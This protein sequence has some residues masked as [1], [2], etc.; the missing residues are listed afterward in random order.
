MLVRDLFRGDF[1]RTAARRAPLAATLAILAGL[2]CHDDPAGP[3]I[4]PTAG[5]SFVPQFSSSAAMVVDFVRVRIVFLR[6]GTNQVALDTVV[7]FPSDADSI[8]LNL[9]VPTQGVGQSENLSFSLAMI[10]AAGDTV[11]RGGPNFVT[12]T[13]GGTTAPVLVP[14]HYTGVG[15]NAASVRI[16][17]RDTSVFFNDSVVLTAVAFDSANQ[18]ISGTPIEWTSL[19]TTRALVPHPNSGKVFGRTQRGPARIRARLVTGQADTGLVRVQPVPSALALLAGNGQSG[20]VGAAL[21]QPLAVRVTAVDGLGVVGVKV[22]FTVVSGGGTVDTLVVTDTAGSA[23]AQLRLGTLAGPDTVRAAVTGLT[24]SPVTFVATALPGAAKTLVI[25]VQPG[26]TAAGSP[27]APAVQVAARD[28]FGNAAT[29][30]TGTVTLA[31]GTNPASGT[32]S[33]TTAVAAVAGVATF[34]AVSINRPG[35]GYTLTAT[36]AGLAAAT[37]GAFSVVPG[38]PTRLGFGVQPD[39]TVAG[40]L[41]APAARVLILDA[42]GNTVTSATD[43]VTIAFGVNPAGGVLAGTLRVAAVA[44]VADFPSL[45]IAKA[46]TGYTLSATSGTLT[47]ATSSPFTISV[48]AAARLAFTVQPGATIAGVAIAPAPLVTVQDSVGNT[49][50]ASTASITV[51]IGTNPSSGTLSGTTIV[52]AVGGTASFSTL[53]IDKAGAGY[54][55]TAAASGLTGAT[56]SALTVSVGAAAKLAFTVQPS[57]VVL[58]AVITPAVQVTIQDAQGNSVTSATTSVTLAITSGTGTSGAV[59]GG[60]LTQAAIAGVATFSTLTVNKVGIGYTLTAT[61]TS[62]TGVTSSAF[63]ASVGAAAKLAF[64]VQPS[65]V[66]AGAAITPAVQV[67]VQDAQ[68]NTVTSATTSVTLAITSGTGTGGAVLGGTL[69]QSA[70]NG[71]ATFSGLTLDRVGTG[72]TLTAT[73]TGLTS[74]TSSAIAVTP[75]AAAALALVSGNSQIGTVSSGV[76]DSLV[77]KATDAFGNAVSGVT[78]N[79]STATGSLTAASTPTGAT[80][81]A[82]VRWT[83]GAPYGRQTAT[84][85]A[86]G[87]GTAATFQA[88][89][90]PAGTTHRWLGISGDWNTPANWSAGTEPVAASNVFIPASAFAPTAPTVSAPGAANDVVAET[91]TT[92]GLGANVLTVSGNLDVHT[93]TATTGGK[94]SLTGIG[95]TA[96]GALPA[97]DVAGRYALSGA[98]TVGGVLTLSGGANTGLKVNGFSLVADSLALPNSAVLVMQNAA[99]SAVINH[100]AWFNG[101]AAND[102]AMTAG[103]LRVRGDLNI[104]SGPNFAAAG[105]HRTVLDGSSPQTVTMAGAGVSPTAAHFRH[106]EIANTWSDTGVTFASTTTQVNGDLTL[107]AA[108]T[109]VRGPSS[110]LTVQGSVNGGLTTKLSL[111][112]LRIGGA[113]NQTGTYVAGLTEFFGTAQTIPVRPYQNVL[114]SGRASFTGATSIGGEL[115]INGTSAAATVNG[116]KVTIADSL[117][118]GDVGGYLVMRNPADQVVVNGHAYFNGTNPIQDTILTAGVLRLRR[119]LTV[120]YAPSFAASTTGAHRTVFDGPSG[121]GVQIIQFPAGSGSA[122][123]AAKFRD[124]V[125]SRPAAA[126]VVQIA[127]DVF[128]SDT[129][130][131]TDTAGTGRLESATNGALLMPATGVLRQ[132]RATGGVFVRRAEVG[133]IFLDSLGSATGIFSPDTVVF[134]A[135]GT[136][137]SGLGIAYKSVRIAAD[138]LTAP[139]A[140]TIPN[141]LVIGGASGQT[142]TLALDLTAVVSVGGNLRTE[143]QGSLNMRFST[144]SLS[145]AGNATFAGGSTSGRLTAG[146][147]QLS[148][149]FTQAGPT[150]TAFAPSGSHRVEF[151]SSALQTVSFANPGTGLSRFQKL[152]VVG[153]ASY[154]DTVQLLSDVFV[155]DSL[156]VR[157]KST[158]RGASPYRLVVGGNLVM[159]AVDTPSVRPF[160]LEVAG[161]LGDTT[162]LIAP[163]TLVLNRSDSYSIVQQPYK[164]LRVNNGTA[165]LPIVT[166]PGD[167]EVSGTGAV[168]IPTGTHTVTGNFRT[169]GSGTLQMQSADGLFV[170]QGNVTFAG[171]STST[172]LTAGTL[173]LKGNFAQSGSTTTA[174]APSGNHIVQFNGSG[175][176]TVTFASPGVDSSRFQVWQLLRPSNAVDSVQLA[177][178]VYVVDSI[179]VRYASVVGGKSPRRLVVGGNVR[180]GSLNSPALR[181]FVLEV[182]GTLG[183]TGVAAI[184]PDTLVYN[185]GGS[186]SIVQQPFKHLRVNSGTADLQVVMVAG[187]LEVSGTG[188]VSIPTSAHTVTGNF[189]TT[190]SGT[191]QMQTPTGS[192]VVQG[193]ATFAGGS[194]AG[195]LTAGLLLVGGNFTQLGTTSFQASGGPTGHTTIFTNPTVPQTVSF[196]APDTLSEGSGTHSGSHFGNMEMGVS[197]DTVKLLTDAAVQGTFLSGDISGPT[198]TGTHTLFTRGLSQSGLTIDGTLLVLLRGEPGQNPNFGSMTFRNQPKTATQFWIRRSETCLNFYGLTFETVPE[199]DG[200]YVGVENLSGSS[201]SIYFGSGSPASLEPFVERIGSPSI[202]WTGSWCGVY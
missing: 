176:Q 45:R 196:A 69:T 126:D 119:N 198:L 199:N 93:V 99:D 101:G 181:P 154:R 161:T 56:S 26:T 153:Q 117:V 189:S 63:A 4:S 36:A 74:A 114:V 118:V 167:L 191:L 168:S 14:I 51:A 62:L 78:V 129:A 201:Q 107:V 84:A 19:D 86:A 57:A 54:T 47:G 35:T 103:V 132:R 25:A 157:Y 43:S 17:V 111:S 147:L 200:H 67:T 100:G 131:V 15:S 179:A 202:N 148:G 178:N 97:V 158:I 83:L 194:T 40:A 171:G 104:A 50:T 59:L 64:T 9:A 143:G 41:L 134:L 145:V 37:T 24:G 22:R 89:A 49:V 120:P 18:P 82:Y 109:G 29:A 52:S 112:A 90:Q 34:S 184:Q 102:T 91:G 122:T 6:A 123:G 85:S 79:W 95:K 80:G 73:A 163:D 105:T 165:D 188:N 170:V 133:T 2:S 98:T 70:V 81:V 5:F 68:G 13:A 159:G 27:I 42:I 7:S 44:G 33:G 55:L 12:V 96:V 66:V 136:L 21:A 146:T 92:I 61:A 110:T 65:A 164:H 48:G 23:A 185:T 139:S 60:T 180:V 20:T 3:R 197:G 137:P 150:T 156:A 72:Y 1:A 28:T 138:T 58:G 30:F 71:V 8:T 175:L 16:A 39:T 193:K 38:A 53:S 140:L 160:V 128:V 187:D 177:S 77:V 162:N 195:L 94:L 121:N 116:Q 169:T 125:I 76:T 174:F 124:L 183:D 113:L 192:L 88:L 31:I 141:D 144:A 182:T 190:G 152:Q 115:R 173:Q 172:L 46:D 186:Y 149:N 142:G 10:N 155:L 130:I 11:F 135:P 87:V 108:G 127:S 32:L 166:V 106:L 75:A 151:N